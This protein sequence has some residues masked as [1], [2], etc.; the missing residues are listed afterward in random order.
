MMSNHAPLLLFSTFDALE[1][2]VLILNSKGEIALWNRWLVKASSRHSD[3]LIGLPLSVAFPELKNTRVEQAVK[4]AIEKDQSSFLSQCLNRAPFNL[5]R[6]H[7]NDEVPL[8]MQQQIQITPLRQFND[9]QFCLIQIQDV[10]ASVIREQILQERAAELHRFA[11]QDGLTGI[12]N[13]R[14]Y[15]EKLA[16]EWRRAVRQKHPLSV[17][18]IDIDFFK[19]YNDHLGHQQGDT[20]LQDIAKAL[21]AALRRPTDIIARYG[22]EEFIVLLPAT[23][24][25]GCITIAEQLLEAVRELERPHPD[26]PH[27]IATVSIG[28]ASTTPNRDTEASVLI[29]EADLALYF[30]KQ[31]GRNQLRD[32]QS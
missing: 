13:R 12:P 23:P 8:R 22:G 20:C 14:Y 19:R 3:D 18:M 32:S 27:H 16:E 7:N 1:L 24:M 21:Q 15:E 5:F 30:A 26:S 25:A 9:E 11:Y 29:Q 10:T 17:L 31:H 28:C 2:G 6:L 4:L